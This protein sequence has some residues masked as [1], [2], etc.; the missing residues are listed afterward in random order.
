[1]LSRIKVVFDFYQFFQIVSI[2][3]ILR[4]IHFKFYS[5]QSQDN[6]FIYSKLI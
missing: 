1:M 3:H 4:Y 6:F 5:H 2:V